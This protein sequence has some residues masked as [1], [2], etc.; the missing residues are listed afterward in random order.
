[1]NNL[2]KYVIGRWSDFYLNSPSAT[3]AKF[4]IGGTTVYVTGTFEEINIIYADAYIT[5]V[6]NFDR[7]L[8]AIEEMLQ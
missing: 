6:K 7:M 2:I 4:R 3:Q 1:M 8:K 5:C